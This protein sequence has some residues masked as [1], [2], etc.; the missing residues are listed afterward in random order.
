MRQWRW[1]L[2]VGRWKAPRKPPARL[3]SL[4]KIT[5]LFFPKICTSRGTTLKPPWSNLT[6]ILGPLITWSFLKLIRSRTR[7]K[8][9]LSFRKRTDQRKSHLFRLTK[10]LWKT[11][12]DTHR[13][14]CKLWVTPGKDSGLYR[15]KGPQICSPHRSF[16]R[17]TTVS[18]TPL[19]KCLS[20]LDRSEI[21]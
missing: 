12:S 17:T 9:Q 19:L 1:N 5:P 14:L 16:P 6:P 2:T 11:L 18:G 10:K 3:T 15:G 13:Y 8:L 21:A 7:C 20:R 4:K